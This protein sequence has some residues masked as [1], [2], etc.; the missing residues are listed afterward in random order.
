MS[1]LFKI[2]DP[3]LLLFSILVIYFLAPSLDRNQA[4]FISTAFAVINI[5][6][7][8]PTWDRPHRIRYLAYMFIAIVTYYILFN[9]QPWD[10][11]F[12]GGLFESS[13]WPLIVCSLLMTINGWLLFD[14]WRQRR[15]YAFITLGIQ[16]PVAIFIGGQYLQETFNGTAQ[17]LKF[18]EHYSGSWQV[19]QFEW[20]LT[21]YLPIFILKRLKKIQ[22][23]ETL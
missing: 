20:M 12:H 21:Y 1:Q 15:L 14:D 4:V 7:A 22:K 8:R 17:A 3:V 23:I 9:D 16:V 13:P 18:V 19:W 10:M 6:A 11:I 2:K 5:L